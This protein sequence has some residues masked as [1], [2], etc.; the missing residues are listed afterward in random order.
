MLKIIKLGFLIG[1]LLLS[2]G[3]KRI[4]NG[5]EKH[6]LEAIELY[7][8]RRHYY[9]HETDGRTNTLFNGL[10]LSERLMLGIA[11]LYDIRAYAFYQKGIPIVAAD[12]V[13]MDDNLGIGTPIDLA[14]PFTAALREQVKI[15]IEQFSP[16]KCDFQ[17]AVDQSVQM[18]AWIDNFEKTNQIYLPMTK[19]VV[20]SI[21]FAALHA[22]I[23]MSQSAGETLA[24]SCDLVNLQVG[25]LKRFISISFDKQANVFHQEGVG[26]LVNDLPHIPFLSEFHA[27]SF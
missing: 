26:V 22:P 24:L 8:E 10:I 17:G 3:C 1:V 11:H 9:A 15:R 21:G 4:E 20:E 6:L 19:H 23:Y 12:F 7:S 5:A 16:N 2:Q 25:T 13:S 14:K 18:L 27:N